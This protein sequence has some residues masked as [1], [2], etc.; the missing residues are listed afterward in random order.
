VR[1]FG[2]RQLLRLLG[3]SER[4]MAWLA[5]APEG[6]EQVLVIPRQQPAHPGELR[7]WLDEVK[8]AARLQHPNL[9]A[10][11]EI[12]VQDGWPFVAYAMQ[13]AASLHE[14]LGRQGLPGLEAAAMAVAVLEGLA[15]A[16]EGGVAHHDVQAHLILVDGE[17]RPRL[18][19]LAVGCLVA[20]TQAREA[21]WADD[22]ATGRDRP[23][24]L[25]PL[26]PRALRRMRAAAERDLLALGIVWH[27]VLTG[28]PALDE[29]DS[30]A[31]I[32]RMPPEGR[33][34]VRLPWSG[35]QAI[36]EPL[37]T[38]FN[39]A[40]DRQERQRYR[41]A[42]TLARA[43]QGWLHSETDADG[44]PLGL[45]GDRLRMAGVLPAAPGSAERAVRL[46]AMDRER[47]HELAEVVI[48]D[49]AL[50]FEMLRLVNAA[51]GRSPLASGG[52]VMTV[53]RSIAMLGMD[54]LRNAAQALRRWPGP[55]DEPAAAELTRSIERSKRA[56]RLALQLRPAGYD[57]EV[58]YLV[59]LMQNLG[60]LIVQYH[61]ADEAAQIRR[62]MQPTAPTRE[63]EPEEP[64]MAEASACFAVLGVDAE[65]IGQAVA[66]QWGLD[67]GV[68][69]MIRRLPL[70]TAVR[71]PEGD[72]AM[73]RLVASCANE[74][75]DATLLPAAKAASAMQRVVQR[76]G[77]VLEIGTRELGD[78]LKRSAQAVSWNATPERDEQ[79]T[80]FGELGAQT[81]F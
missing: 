21:E 61:F 69:A 6:D 46:I 78:A 74:A 34:I 3:K 43:L 67:D 10:A 66:R 47:T 42:R 72:S 20:A 68:L 27:R 54:A 9:A 36:A 32:A 55:L 30:G 51:V 23:G 58:V 5:A 56:G 28:Q 16:H 26:D 76:Y 1:W 70:E 24:A 29:T 50:A 73:L 40:T 33:E 62:L 11:I 31:A 18:A 77:R 53:R 4:T 14:R 63:G 17:G 75:M 80:G 44:S 7:A 64:G 22:P 35:T 81:R 37:R 2:P 45:L 39:R 65:A 15:F 19:G 49:L 12:G 41:S 60:R 48:E 8:Q 38:I 57:A 79:R 59:T 25:A 71:T 13:G 52:A